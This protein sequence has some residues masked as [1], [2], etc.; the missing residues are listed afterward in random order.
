[1]DKIQELSN[2]LLILER[3]HYRLK[4]FAGFV[5]I[6]TCSLMLMGQV[7]P[8]LDR[9]LTPS[10]QST[11][12]QTSTHEGTIRAEAFILTDAKGKERASLVT[13]GTGSV[14]LVLFDTDGRPRADLQVNNF[15]P[16]LNF[17]DP[18]AKTRLALGSTSL[19]ASHVINNGTVEKNTPS[20]I[21]LFDAAGQ[22]LWRTP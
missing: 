4:V 2:R 22:L 12:T 5:A 8:P 10:T 13:D 3:Q 16:S 20:S 9:P 15:G 17:Y 7:R 1:M 6:V 19:V 14:F 18:N 11:I 21:V